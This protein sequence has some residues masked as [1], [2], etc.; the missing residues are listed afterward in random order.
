MQL[1][2]LGSDKLI[3]LVMLNKNKRSHRLPSSLA[4]EK[5]SATMLLSTPIR[6]AGNE[7]GVQTGGVDEPNWFAVLSRTPSSDT[8]AG[9][10]QAKTIVEE[11]QLKLQVTGRQHC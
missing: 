5:S 4:E 9:R 1:L 7:D 2:G 8:G 11:F 3:S 6:L 10:K